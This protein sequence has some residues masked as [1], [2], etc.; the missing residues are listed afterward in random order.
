MSVDP[1]DDCT[2][3]YV[4]QYFLSRE[5]L[6][7]PDRLG[8]V[9]ERERRR[10]V[11]LT[12]QCITR[13]TSR[14]DDRHG[15]RAGRQPDHR[16]V[17]GGSRRRPE[18]T[19]SS[20]RTGRA[21]ARGSYEPVGWTAGTEHQLHRH[22][23]CRGGIVYSYRVHRR[24]DAAGRCQST[25]RQR[26][27][28]RDG[29]RSVQLE[30]DLR[31]RRRGRQRGRQQL[32]RDDQLGAGVRRVP[33][34][35]EPALQHLPRDRSR[36]RSVGREPHRDLRRRPE[37]LPRHRPTLVERR[38]LLLRRPRGG[39]QHGARRRVRRGQRGIEQRR[40]SRHRPT[41]RTGSPLRHLVGR[42]R[43]RH[44]VHAPE[45]RGT[46]GYERPAVAATSRPATTRAPIT[47][48][49]APTPTATRVLPPA[50]C[51][52]PNTCAE[53]QTPPLTR[54]GARRS[55]CK[56]WERHQ[57]EYHWDGI[58]VEYSVNGGAWTDVP[59]PSNAP[60]PKVARATDDTTG[61]ERVELHADT[62]DQCVRVPGHEA[63]VQRSVRA[64]ASPCNDFAT[65]PAEP[66]TPTGATRSPAWHPSDTIRS[67]G[68][69]PPTPARISPGFYLDDVAITN[70]RRAQRLR[71][72][73]P[74]RVRPT[75]SPA[76]TASPARREARAARDG[77]DPVPPA[78]EVVCGAGD[79]VSRE[80]PISWTALQAVASAT[81][82]SHR[83][84]SD[85]QAERT[86]DGRAVS[87]TTWPDRSTVDGRR[88]PRRRATA[89]TTWSAAQNAS[90]P[91]TYGHSAADVEL[92]SRRRGAQYRTGPTRRLALIESRTYIPRSRQSACGWDYGKT[93]RH[94]Y[95][96][97][98]LATLRAR[99]GRS[100]QSAHRRHRS[101]EACTLGRHL[102]AHRMKFSL[103]ADAN[104]VASAGAAF[105]GRTSSE[106][107]VVYLER[108]PDGARSP[109]APRGPF[110]MEQEGLAFRPH[111]L[112]IEKGTEVEFPNRDMLFHNV[113]SL[114]TPRDVRSRAVPQNAS[115]SLT[116]DK[117]GHR[118]GLLPHPLRHERRD[119][120]ARQLVLCVSRP[121]RASSPSTA[122]RRANTASSRGTSGLACPVKRVRV[123]SGKASVLD[124]EIP[125][126]EDENGG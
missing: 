86:G 76:T 74:A 45:R 83:R 49:A 69:S 94:S 105:D 102:A 46:R 19:T 18:P 114:S 123:E 62:P 103:Y 57:I 63:G 44:R 75:A 36:L 110:R 4:S 97:A 104:R 53:M 119:H 125:L 66:P 26:L 20:A 40:H 2:F 112:A 121:R 29:D 43:G 22:R 80:R 115:K 39:Q 47:R 71:P 30:A 59:A 37:L 28:R 78:G 89:T 68:G 11:P 99:P 1:F 77:D 116:F 34:D 87:P 91:G 88:E 117:P 32:R 106:N 61:W 35:P 55:T 7:D 100:G 51:T 38:D 118:Q 31:R 64:A 41:D 79:T 109:T 85:L 42:R 58:A 9:A 16:D 98:I 107:V 84:C 14:P 111:V 17:D 10:A 82:S 72:P 101:A 33:A 15:D 50:A 113:F 54:R 25:A 90:C 65:G 21:G 52:A 73:T 56:Y 124:F 3:W 13:P 67:G 92:P 126:S 93:R 6:V 27:R 8:R 108:A 95:V 122:S 24:A 12:T 60:R 70:L 48:P 96:A 5:Q 81:T 120:G 23:R